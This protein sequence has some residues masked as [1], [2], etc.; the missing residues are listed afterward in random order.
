MVR[1]PRRRAPTQ[2]IP[3]NSS[4]TGMKTISLSDELSD[5]EDIGDRQLR[6]KRRMASKTG[7]SKSS[8]KQVDGIVKEEKKKKKE[9]PKYEDEMDP[10]DSDPGE[11]YRDHCMKINGLSSSCLR[12]PRRIKNIPDKKKELD[13]TTSEATT[14]PSPASSEIDDILLNTPETLPANTTRVRYS[15]RTSIGDGSQNQP[16]GPSLMARR[17]LRP[18]NVHVNVSHWSECGARPYMEDR[19]EYCG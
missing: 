8:L 16:A 19:Y 7:V 10:Y 5:S 2:P 4:L 11:S 6:S 14:P 15:L 3:G 17:E 12:M 9:K 18:N 1:L 13:G